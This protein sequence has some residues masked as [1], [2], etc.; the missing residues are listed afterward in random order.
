MLTKKILK[1][2]IKEDWPIRSIPPDKKSE[3]LLTFLQ[4]KKFKNGRSKQFLFHGTKEHPSDFNLK[5]DWEGDSGNTYD[6]AELPEGYLFLTNDIMEAKAYG[7]YIIPCELKHCD[8]L[9]IRVDSN[10]PSRDFDDDFSGYGKYAMWPKFWESGKSVLEVK[11]YSKSTFI[12]DVSNVI[13]RTDLAMEFYSK[14]ENEGQDFMMWHGSG[15]QIFPFQNFDEKMIGSGLVTAKKNKG[16]FF[17]DDKENAEFYSE[18]FV[19]K[20]L[21]E[22]VKKT[23]IKNPINA[24]DSAF[25]NKENYMVENVLDGAYY[26]DVVVVP[27]NNLDTIKIVEWR[28]EGDEE[29][30]FEAYDK[31]FGGNDED[32][33]WIN[34]DTIKEVVGLLD[35]D[36]NYLLRVPIFKKYFN[37]KG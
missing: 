18:Y 7:R 33:D 19:A 11:G 15:S 30:L 6:I 22:N 36:L 9:T 21:I 27:K 31:L 14:K 2:I 25:E 24:L 23:E 28:F 35:L 4:G 26:S 20:C 8:K 32:T 29:S 1:Q 17:T 13:P 16:F 37:S 10:T 5:D 34:Q 12:T 3:N